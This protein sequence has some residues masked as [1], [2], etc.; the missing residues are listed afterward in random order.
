MDAAKIGGFACLTIGLAIGIGVF[1]AASYRFSI[2]ADWEARRCDPGV[3]VSAGLFKPANDPR[4]ASQFATDNLQHCQKN[5]VQDALRVAAAGAK[6]LAEAEDSVVAVVGEMTSVLTDVF[7]DLW[8]FCYEAYSSFMESMKGAAKLFQNFFIKLHNIIDRIQ[9]A[10]LA[11]VFG[12]M[13]VVT[14]YVSIIQVVLIVAI[15][16]I[17]ILIALQILLFFILL[18]ISGLIILVSSIVSVIVVAV[19]TAISAAM[20]SELFS[21]GEGTCFAPGTQVA[22]GPDIAAHKSIEQ[23]RVGDT[24]ADG[25]TVT[26][27][28]RFWS[29]DALYDLRGIQVTGDHLV[30]HPVGS[31]L[32]PVSEHILAQRLSPSWSRRLLGGQ[33]LW[34]LTTTT[35]RIPVRAPNGALIQFAD[36][37]EIPEGDMKTL[38]D[39]HAAVWRKLNGSGEASEAVHIPTTEILESEAGLAPDCQVQVVSWTGQRSWMRIADVPV[40][41]RIAAGGGR[42]TKVVGRVELDGEEVAA[43]VNLPGEDDQP[44][45]VSAGSWI[46]QGM[47]S[48]FWGSA[49]EGGRVVKAAKPDQWIHLYTESG[50]FMIRGGWRIRDAS[51][52][53][54]AALKPLV[55]SIVLAP[56][57]A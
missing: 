15:V 56:A 32:I 46:W 4:T 42:T 2:S 20:V 25:G 22:V 48:G 10:A 44:Q 17:G 1:I 50:E 38:R 13:A 54:L 3:V 11:I 37:E 36:W 35:R 18:P 43:C 49:E 51:E 47:C 5:Y 57:S 53:G 7:V 28:H 31:A 30:A 6:E 33:E 41:A 12:L 45:L 14:A 29:R 55:E 24:L 27:V 16:I 9:G 26:A 39:W 52:V 23:I 21:S 34:C 19:A 40:G 8:N